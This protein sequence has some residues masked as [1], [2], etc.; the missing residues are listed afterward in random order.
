MSTPSPSQRNLSASPNSEL[1]PMNGIPRHPGEYQYMNNSPLPGHL[2]GEYHVPNQSAPTT[3]SFS[4]GM[5]PTSHPTGYGPPSI[6]EPPANMEQRQPGS[7]N[8]SPHMSSVGWQSPSQ[9]MPSPSQSN[10]YVYPDPDPYGGAAINQHMYYQ[11]SSN[12]RRPGS[13]EP[14]VAYDIKPRMNETWM[15]A[16]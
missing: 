3:A 13:I 16:Q 10:G 8:G 11:N 6:L 5:R 7:A 1:A 9:N 14:D 2:R 12:V 15:A 4:N